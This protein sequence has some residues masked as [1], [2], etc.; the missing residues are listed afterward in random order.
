MT[1][2]HVHVIAVV[3]VN[4]SVIDWS[5]CDLDAAIGIDLICYANQLIYTSLDTKGIESYS[6]RGIKS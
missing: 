3:V 4:K 6:T 1:Q 2:S 5:Q